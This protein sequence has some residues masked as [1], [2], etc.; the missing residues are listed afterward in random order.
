MSADIDIPTTYT[1]NMGGGIDLDLDEIRVKE[2][3][4]VTFHTDSTVNMGLDDIRINAFPDNPL[5]TK[6]EVDLGLDNIQV[7]ALPRLELS[8]EVSIKPTRV[9]LPMNYTLSFG[10]LNLNLF[11]VSLCGEGM[12]VVED[13]EPRDTERCD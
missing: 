12:V 6:S 7:K 2:F 10:L 9:H 1:L 4:D 3:P 8:T 11:S 5:Q 13:Y